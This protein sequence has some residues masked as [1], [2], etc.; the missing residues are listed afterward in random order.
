MLLNTLRMSAFIAA[1]LMMTG[2]STDASA[3]SLTGNATAAVGANSTV[4]ADVGVGVGVGTSV[5]TGQTGQTGNDYSAFSRTTTESSASAESRFRNS[6]DDRE[7]RTT[8]LESGFESSTS[9]SGAM[10]T[11]GSFNE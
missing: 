2:F 1:A 11:G 9:A 6:D 3:G 7:D 5:Q 4:G 8:R 10:T